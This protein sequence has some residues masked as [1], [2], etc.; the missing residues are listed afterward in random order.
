MMGSNVSRREDSDTGEDFSENGSN[1]S[2]TETEDSEDDDD[3]DTSSYQSDSSILSNFSFTGTNNNWAS[4]FEAKPL[5]AVPALK[6]MA[7]VRIAVAL[8]NHAKISDAMSKSFKINEYTFTFT[9]V[10]ASEVWDSLVKKVYQTSLELRVPNSIVEYINE[11]V[12]KLHREIQ[13]WVSYHRRKVFLT[14][15]VKYAFVASLVEDLIWHSNGTIDYKGTAKHLIASHK[16]SNVMKYRLLCSYCLKDDI[17][18]MSPR[19]LV[20]DTSNRLDRELHPIIHYWN[21]YYRNELHKIPK[22]N[23][24]IDTFM[25]ENSRVDNWP[26]KEYFFNRLSAEQQVQSASRLI[27]TYGVKYQCF[28]LTKLNE[29]QRLSLYSHSDQAIEILA[30]FAKT[31]S[32]N[33]DARSTWLEIRN[34]IKREQFVRLFEKLLDQLNGRII[35][36]DI[37]NNCCDDFKHYIFNYNDSQII[38]AMLKHYFRTHIR[39]ILL[40]VLSDSSK[41]VKSEITKKDAFKKCCEELIEKNNFQE[42]NQLLSSCFPAREDLAEFKLSMVKESQSVRN[43]CLCYYYGITGPSLQYLNDYLTSLLSPAHTDFIIE[44]KRNLLMS[45]DGIVTCA[46]SVASKRD[47]LNEILAD[48]SASDDFAMKFKKKV[49]FSGT[50]VSRFCYKISKN[51][52]MNVKECV[53]RHLSSDED[54]KI[55]KTA[56]IDD[57][58]ALMRQIIQKCPYPQWQSLLLWYFENEKIIKQVKC[59]LPLNDVFDEILRECVFNSYE[60]YQSAS[61]RS[62]KIIFIKLN[63]FLAWYF[64]SS[65]AAKN[66]KLQRVDLFKKIPMIS[67]LMEKTNSTPF[68]KSLMSWFFDN[69][70]QE[71]EKFERKHKGAKIVKIVRLVR[72]KCCK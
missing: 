57:R 59:V 6:E 55:L 27:D 10:K 33:E 40:T 5:G 25:F 8:W 42:L 67:E 30:N 68:L 17:E 48:I 16:L 69:D 54:K 44:Y 45:P 7:A 35:L 38:Y 36:Q 20:N 62:V 39:D 66:Y 70:I 9:S 71:I 15:H 37:W 53:D 56:L 3:S 34:I 52:L 32:N 13:N 29:I 58:V 31:G 47:Q 28:L 43:W 4:V 1:D 72:K 51:R 46:L 14:N 60:K 12:F 41:E 19:S 64:K 23:G 26:A 49:L 2:L 21:C 22:R 18:T 63:K 24:S 65:D 11:Y 50:A 61:R